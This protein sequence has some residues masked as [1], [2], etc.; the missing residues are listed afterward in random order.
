MLPEGPPAG[1]RGDRRGASSAGADGE[2]PAP[3]VG[4]D[5][6]AQ[7]RQ[8]D[9]I[10]AETETLTTTRGLRQSMTQARSL[11]QPRGA[12]AGPGRSGAAPG[13]TSRSAGTQRSRPRNA[14]TARSRPAAPARQPVTSRQDSA[15]ST[16]ACSVS[17]CALVASSKSAMHSSAGIIASPHSVCIFV[18]AC[19]VRDPGPVN[20]HPAAAARPKTTTIPTHFPIEVDRPRPRSAYSTFVPFT[21][22]D[23]GRA[24][25]PS[26][27]GP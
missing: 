22:V 5:F 12:S 1:A 27:R 14:P 18:Q 24:P 11:C 6:V 15:G 17:S 16:H 10:N 2:R 23:R 3:A 4:L 8:S 26:C 20:H 19:P 9:A 13:S 25:A 21:H 7:P